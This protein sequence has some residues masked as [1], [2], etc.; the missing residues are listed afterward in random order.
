MI[1]RSLAVAAV[2]AL[3]SCGGTPAEPGETIPRFDA[4]E[5]V[6]KGVILGFHRWPDAQEEAVL[7]ETVAGAGLEPGEEFERFRVRV[8]DWPDWRE[9]ERAA[10]V[11]EEIV[12]LAL[13]SLEY[14]EPNA[15]VGP[16]D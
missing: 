11:C 15:L 1:A 10:A 13:T 14:C 7:L 6:A 12:A 9:A 2:L 8:Y 3:S 5:P 16:A 4:N